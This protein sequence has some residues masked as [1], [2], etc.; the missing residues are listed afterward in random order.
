MGQA[1]DNLRRASWAYRILRR[2]RRRRKKL[3]IKFSRGPV[4]LL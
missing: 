1:A 4:L 2:K 3:G